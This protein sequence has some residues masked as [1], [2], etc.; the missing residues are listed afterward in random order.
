M[1]GHNSFQFGVELEFL[2]GSRK[3]VHHNWKSLAKDLSKRLQ[4]AGISNHVN[5]GNDKS[6][7]N[8]REWSIVQEVT[9]PSQPAKNLWG[10]ELVSPVYP[11]YSYWAADL[12][13][14]FTALHK[15]FSLVPSPHCSTHVHVSGAPD[16]LSPADLAALA[17]SALYHEPALDL[18]FPPARR[19]GQYWCR[20]IRASEALGGVAALGDCLAVVD[21]AAA[22]AAG[23]GGYAGVV[24]AVNLFPA[25]SPY[26]RAH[27]WKADAVRGKVYKWDFSRMVGAEEGAGAGAATVE[28]RQPPGQILQLIFTTSSQ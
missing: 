4:K 3:K 11:I 2:L 19:A 6:W 5:D 17:K 18:L 10:I 22:A 20:S 23:G 12:D 7:E 25:A 16:P 26:G 15:A 8:Y 9:I 28:F 13:T 14:I 27:G 24:E 1:E 21:R